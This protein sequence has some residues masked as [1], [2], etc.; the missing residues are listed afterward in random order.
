MT[1]LSAYLNR[2]CAF[3]VSKGNLPFTYVDNDIIELFKPHG[4]IASV[5]YMR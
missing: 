3:C 1:P 5:R 2:L 4:E